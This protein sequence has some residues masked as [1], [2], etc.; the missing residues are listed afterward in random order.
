MK[1]KYEYD[2]QEGHDFI[3]KELMS[4]M[5]YRSSVKVVDATLRDGGL[6]N[7]FMFSDEFTKALYETNIRAGVDYMEFGYKASK[8]MFDQSKFGKWKFCN[9][10]DIRAIVGDNQTDLK[11]AVMA[12]VGRC[13]YKKD[14][15][16][17]S[18]S[19]IDLVRVST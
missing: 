17:R 13:D 8:D 15:V 10:D 3:M 2:M 11:L 18:D 7:D 4:L 16:N 9:D 12:D 14:I 19:P 6:V 1:V 5:D